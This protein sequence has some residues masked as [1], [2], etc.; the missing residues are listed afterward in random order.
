MVSP[1]LETSSNELCN[2]GINCMG[3]E[4]IKI[5]ATPGSSFTP[6]PL[7]HEE[8]VG[9]GHHRR[10]KALQWRPAR[11]N[12]LNPE[13]GGAVG[14]IEK[15]FDEARRNTNAKDEKWTKYILYDRRRR[16]V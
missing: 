3:I 1:V 16:D 14:D 13:A 6:T 5:I 10:S 4:Y 8:N 15:M 12:F 7:D 9:V 11:F 2:S